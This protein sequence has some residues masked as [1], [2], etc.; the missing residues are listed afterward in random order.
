MSA[1]LFISADSILPNSVLFFS[2]EVR[3][4]TEQ[5]HSFRPQIYLELIVVVL[6]VFLVVYAGVV[7]QEV[8]QRLD[9]VTIK[10]VVLDPTVRGPVFF[11]GLCSR[12]GAWAF[13]R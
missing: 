8:Y 2:K 6:L 1:Q 5:L 11:L 12:G 13:L 4:A 7:L 3:A 10:M 9:L